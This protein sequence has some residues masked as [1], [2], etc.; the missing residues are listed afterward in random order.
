MAIA[1]FPKTQLNKPNIGVQLNG[2]HPL[3]YGLKQ[4]LLINEGGGQTLNA[5]V[6]NN[7]AMTGISWVPGF[8]GVAA[9]F[10]GVSGSGVI[11]CPSSL[12]GWT[13]FALHL[14][15][16]IPVSGSGS[17]TRYFEKGA[18]NEITITA[19]GGGTWFQVVD[20]VGT[21]L[22]NVTGVN[23][24]LWR[25]YYFIATSAGSY[26]LYV[27]GVLF[28]SGTGA[29]FGSTRS[30]DLYLGRF[31]GGGFNGTFDLVAFN[32]WSRPNYY[33]ASTLTGSEQVQL[34]QNPFCFLQ[35]QSPQD[36][37]W[38]S[39]AAVPASTLTLQWQGVDIH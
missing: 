5:L 35:P 39:A 31:G 18:N 26:A 23:D 4:S 30:G 13:D 21:Q 8:S 34:Y 16:R 19:S 20:S 9:S 10:D 36:R 37:Y 25:S 32:V 29:N 24:N 22:F 6:G 14:V 27:N 15:M 11:T 1:I 17:N 28:G 7:A 33:S 2:S 38:T 12:A 3:A